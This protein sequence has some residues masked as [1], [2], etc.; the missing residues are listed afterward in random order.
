MA[1]A[2]QLF[3][4]LQHKIF[5]LPVFTRTLLAN[6]LVIVTGAVCG[7]IIT[8]QLTLIGNFK[9][10]LLFASLGIGLTLLVN[11]WVV[12]T[13]S[14]PLLQLRQTVGQV[15]E[16][17]SSL[18]ETLPMRSDPDVHLLVEAI[19]SMLSRLDRRTR[20]LRALSERAI[21]AQEE[22]RKRIAR[23]LH[24][25]TAQSISTLIIQLE[26]LED[27]LPVGSQD[28]RSRLAEARRL[29]N[30][31]L[32]NLREIIWN[33]RPAILDDLGLVPAIRWYARAH[34]EK[35]GIKVQ[36][37]GISEKLHLPSHLEII[38]FR[39]IQ[40]AVSNILSHSDARMVTIRL[41]YINSDI[42]LEVE[43]DGCGFDVEQTASEAVMRKQLGLLG[44]QER[45]SLV[46]GEVRVSSTPGVGTRLIVRVPLEQTLATENN[47]LES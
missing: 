15:T 9:L 19:N 1:A 45:A 11:Y 6:S 10:I 28:L 44:I 31:L 38:L 5:G 17:L 36:L 7:T 16:G 47:R 46:G 40:E 3:D 27:Q 4:S 23:G 18:P 8:R 34:L 41:R 32:E 2:S 37:A 20:Q 12:K 13:A 39:V 22:E 25:E 30:D 33:L 24:D 14:R 35:A 21:N 26:R 43:D 29:A 42:C